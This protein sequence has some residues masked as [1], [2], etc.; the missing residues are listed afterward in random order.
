MPRAFD[1]RE[2]NVS[3]QI[4]LENEEIVDVS[5][6]WQQYDGVVYDTEDPDIPE[7]Y[8]LFTE[9]QIKGI[10]EQHDTA[11]EYLIGAQGKEEMV[12]ILQHMEGSSQ[13]TPLEEVIEPQE[14][15][16]FTGA[17]IRSSKLGSAVRDAFNR[18]L[19]RE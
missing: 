14:V 17:T 5:L 12:E 18:G 19:Y 13:G 11:L 7:D 1:D 6:R 15:D 9:E 10:V 2:H 4:T 3:V 8:E 16:G